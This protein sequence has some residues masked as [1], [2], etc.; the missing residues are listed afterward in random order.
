VSRPLCGECFIS[1]VM[2]S[3]GCQE[4]PLERVIIPA[5]NAAITVTVLIVSLSWF[6]YSWSPFFPSVGVFTS[7]IAQRLYQT[8]KKNSMVSN[9]ISKCTSLLKTSSLLQ[10]LKIFISYLQVISSFLGF[11]VTWPSSIVHL[12]LW[13]KVTFNFSIL[14]LPGVSCL[15]KELGYNSKLMTYTLVPL[16]LGIMLF[17]PVLLISILQYF[18][19]NLSE[20]KKKTRV[21]IEDRFWNA[22]M[23]MSFLVRKSKSFYFFQ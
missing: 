12:M 17:M 18:K 5:R 7:R 16:V 8:S 6:W 4:C 14:S 21:I 22:I 3:S 23:F 2:T 19:K 15:W 11:Q 9:L 13:C 10:Y 1:A 20:E